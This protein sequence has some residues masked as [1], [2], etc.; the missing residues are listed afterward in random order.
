[1]GDIKNGLECEAKNCNDFQ[2][3]EYNYVPFVVWYLRKLLLN[4]GD[5]GLYQLRLYHTSRKHVKLQMKKSL[6]FDVTL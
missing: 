4:K 3:S 2:F 6:T 1:M 5:A